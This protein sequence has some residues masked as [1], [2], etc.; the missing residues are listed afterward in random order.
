MRF[1]TKLFSGNNSAARDAEA[2]NLLLGQTHN[3][4]Q[5]IAGIVL[6]T[7]VGGCATSVS[8]IDQWERA[9]NVQKLSEVARQ[10]S[11]AP[12]IRRLSLESLARLDWKP[13]NEERLEVYSLFASQNNR[14]EAAILMQTFSAEQFADID[15]DI[16]ACS[17]LL[18][19]SGNWNDSK[20]ARPL[21]DK[22]LT[23]KSKAV[24]ISLCQQVVAHPKIQIK[25]L[26]LAIKLG[27]SGSEDD[28]NGVLLEYGDKTMAEDYLNCGS[29]ELANG[30]RRW[31]NAHGY[32]INSGNGS[33]RSGWGSFS[34]W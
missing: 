28:L 12:Y 16:V 30:G 31:A 7:I 21:Y 5:I 34:K 8:Q 4:V 18:D 27:I 15:K 23:F 25:V 32:S 10:K 14:Q 20:K 29:D 2:L 19:N 11:E 6:T 17:S 13:S 1:L 26:L 24:T 9:G 22:L 33:H 3:L